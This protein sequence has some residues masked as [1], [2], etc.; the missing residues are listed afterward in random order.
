MNVRAGA[1]TTVEFPVI[2]VQEPTGYLLPPWEMDG[3]PRAKRDELG[4]DLCPGEQQL[5]YCLPKRGLD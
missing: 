4:V 3:T 5:I 2:V 1:I